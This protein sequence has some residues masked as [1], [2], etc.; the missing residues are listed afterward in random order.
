LDLQ[1]GAT[2][3]GAGGA[4]SGRSGEPTIAYGFQLQNE[5]QVGLNFSIEIFSLG[6]SRESTKTAGNTITVTFEPT[7][8]LQPTKP[9]PK[10]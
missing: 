7:T 2:A 6:A 8:T 9:S 4:G 10:A 1:P 3:A 5:K